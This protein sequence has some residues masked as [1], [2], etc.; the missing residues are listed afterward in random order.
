MCHLA[1]LIYKLLSALTARGF[2]RSSDLTRHKCIAEKEK[3]THQQK[4]AI[5]CQTCKKYLRSKVGYA[6]H[7]CIDVH[8]KTFFVT[9][10]SS[11]LKGCVSRSK[12]EEEEMSTWVNW[13]GIPICSVF[14]LK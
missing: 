6:V 4:A 14:I 12:Q 11:P 10:S 1:M 3:P 5:E 2:R 7:K 9:L 13:V 8:E